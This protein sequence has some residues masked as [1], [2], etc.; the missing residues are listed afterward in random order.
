[1]APLPAECENTRKNTYVL[2]KYAILLAGRG[3]SWLLNCVF[4]NFCRKNTCFLCFKRNALACGRSLG[5]IVS[6]SLARSALRHRISRPLNIT[7]L[8]LSPLSKNAPDLCYQGLWVGRALHVLVQGS[9]SPVRLCLKGS[10]SGAFS[11]KDP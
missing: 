9:T 3:S 11:F 2:Q 10:K 6:K 5:P 8:T 1:M 7:L 4:L